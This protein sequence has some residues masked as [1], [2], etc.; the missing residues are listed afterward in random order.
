[1][2]WFPIKLPKALKLTPVSPTADRAGQQSHNF[3]E[4]DVPLYKSPNSVLIASLL[5]AMQV[6]YTSLSAV[7]Q[8]GKCFLHTTTV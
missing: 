8:H 4:D 5:T 6:V 2:T 3:H 1:M 7:L